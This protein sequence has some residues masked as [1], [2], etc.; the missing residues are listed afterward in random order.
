M[1]TWNRIIPVAIVALG[2]T[3]LACQTHDEPTT[4]GE[5]SRAVPLDGQ[6]NFRDI[7]GYRTA[8][9]RTVRWDRCTGRGA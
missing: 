8:D 6:A 7:G 1:P 3:T 5:H 2:L 9:G 4:A